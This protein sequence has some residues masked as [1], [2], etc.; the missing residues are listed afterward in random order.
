MSSAVSDALA[1]LC[2]RLHAW[3]LPSSPMGA[4]WRLLVESSAADLENWSDDEAA[5][6]SEAAS[7][8]NASTLAAAKRVRVLLAALDAR[9]DPVLLSADETGASA[10]ANYRALGR[11]N[12]LVE[13]G[14]LIPA[15]AY[16]GTVPE[17]PDESLVIP[18]HVTMESP[19]PITS[20]LV[21]CRW[22]PS[23]LPA[24]VC[25][26]ILPVRE[27]E[28]QAKRLARTP[29]DAIMMEVISLPG[30]LA[31]REQLPQLALAPLIE[32]A[33]DFQI[34]RCSNTDL[35]T[36]RPRYPRERLEMVLAATKDIDVLLFPEMSLRE[37]DLPYLQDLLA[38]KGSAGAHLVLAGI[39][40]APTDDCGNVCDS[41]C[42]HHTLEDIGRNYMVVI[43]SDG[44]VI[45]E[46]D[47]LT[48]W[49][50]A[51]DAAADFGLPPPAGTRL[52]ENIRGG[53]KLVLIDHPAFGRILNLICS[54]LYDRYPTD[55]LIRNGG[56]EL[57]HAAIM[58]RS[59]CWR[60]TGVPLHNWAIRRAHRAAWHGAMTIV[61][62]S[63]GLQVRNN[64]VQPRW[65]VTA[66]P[67]S[68]LSDGRLTRCGIGFAALPDNDQ[69]VSIIHLSADLIP[70]TKPIVRRFDF[71]AAVPMPPASPES[72]WQFGKPK[73]FKALEALYGV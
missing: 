35:Y 52:I 21:H 54:D 2:Q 55:W 24:E 47:K 15:R 18:P 8:L 73:A 72:R 67:P 62:N 42:R 22:V 29:A 44:T 51:G 58:D 16:I 37:T 5:L 57:V 49:D 25:D 69:G 45:A 33:N 39:V 59:L 34:L 11:F 3:A 23:Q 13:D 1:Q 27:G 19:S 66:V 65:D 9:H 38:A 7:T 64:D 12:G 40:D 56:V 6:V 68:G 30:T 63:M 70:A 36:I 26:W 17:Q 32:G 20:W 31:E 4:A 28:S 61:T 48:A 60:W 46:Q 53:D 41:F 10:L 43:D 71:A 14:W 50:I